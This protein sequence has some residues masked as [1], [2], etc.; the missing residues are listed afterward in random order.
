[1]SHEKEGAAGRHLKPNSVLKRRS[2]FSTNFNITKTGPPGKQ[3]VFADDR[4]A[5]ICKVVLVLLIIDPF[6]FLNSDDIC[7]EAVLFIRA[8]TSGGT[9]SKGL[10]RNIV[11]FGS[12]HRETLILDHLCVFLLLEIAL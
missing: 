12:Q 5:S 10:L 4:G 7:G 8:R 9:A 6:S 11:V 2:S 3:I 1:M